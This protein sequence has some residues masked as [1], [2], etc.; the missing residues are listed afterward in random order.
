MTRGLL[1]HWSRTDWS[2]EH[3]GWPVKCRKCRWVFPP[4]PYQDKADVGGGR[5]AACRAEAVAKGERA[6]TLQEALMKSDHEMA[7]RYLPTGETV[8]G[9]TNGVGIVIG[10]PSESMRV[11]SRDATQEELDASV[12][13]AA[14]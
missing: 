6:M 8:V 4:G 2:S 1:E 14:V 5:C 7:I 11:E 13:W 3:L 9:Y 12:E 10:P